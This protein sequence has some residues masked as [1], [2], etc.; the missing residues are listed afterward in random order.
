MRPVFSIVSVA[1]KEIDFLR[2]S[3]ILI[4]RYGSIYD[5]LP[6]RGGCPR[7]VEKKISTTTSMIYQLLYQC[8]T[9]AY[10]I[11]EGLFIAQHTKNSGSHTR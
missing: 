5:N 4:A 3:E 9:L 7:H 2:M 8:D 11:V 6:A 10:P 1:P